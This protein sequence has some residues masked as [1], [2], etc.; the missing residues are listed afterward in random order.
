VAVAALSDRARA[1]AA[2]AA[3]PTVAQDVLR[4]LPGVTADNF[5]AVT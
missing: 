3:L 1:A 5:R 2:S 4:R